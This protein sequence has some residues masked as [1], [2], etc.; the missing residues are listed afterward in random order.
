MT[1]LV[2]CFCY[3]YT[4]NDILHSPKDIYTEAGNRAAIKWI[5]LKCKCFSLEPEGLLYPA[6]HVALHIKPW[7]LEPADRLLVP[8]HTLMSLQVLIPGLCVLQAVC[9]CYYWLVSLQF[10]PHLR[11]QRYCLLLCYDT[12][13]NENNL[14]IANSSFQ[15]SLTIPEVVS[16]TSPNSANQ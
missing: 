10:I 6:V 9:Q 8:L 16:E 5:D 3:L 4:Y 11:Q 7:R 2:L 15:M 13:L 1:Y 14:R 12:L